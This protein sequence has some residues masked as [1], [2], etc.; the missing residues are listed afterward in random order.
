MYT[1]LY[2]V[3]T[4]KTVIV[5]LTTMKTWNHTNDQ[6]TSTLII[7]WLYKCFEMTKQQF[8]LYYPNILMNW[9]DAIKTFH[10]MTRHE[11]TSHFCLQYYHI[12]DAFSIIDILVM[13][14]WHDLQDNLVFIET[15][16]VDCMYNRNALSDGTC[17]CV[18]RE[19]QTCPDIC[20]VS[21]EVVHHTSC[22]VW[23]WSKT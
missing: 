20:H 13:N 12:H 1:K 15:R 11:P 8:Y 6:S 18:Q 5:I 16:N 9:S 4:Q 23:S 14:T 3:I 10:T 21:H 22:V 17:L 7:V 2:S 19:L